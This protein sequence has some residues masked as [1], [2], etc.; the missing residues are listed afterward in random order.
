MI[1]DRISIKKMFGGLSIFEIG[2]DYIGIL[3]SEILFVKE[4]DLDELK[5][6]YDKKIIKTN[7]T[8]DGGRL[9]KKS[10]EILGYSEEI[11]KVSKNYTEFWG[12]NEITIYEKNNFQEFLTWLKGLETY[13][14]IINDSEYFECFLYTIWLIVNKGFTTENYIPNRKFVYGILDH[15][16]YDV[17]ISKKYESIMDANVNHHELNHMKIRFCVDREQNKNIY[18]EKYWEVKY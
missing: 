12:F 2:Y 1:Y 17:D 6:C 16:F 14:T 15:N 7:T 5:N 4:F 11:S 3:D 9:I 10:A 13:E 8:L 18:L